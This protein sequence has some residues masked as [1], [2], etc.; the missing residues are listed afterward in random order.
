[1]SNARD[2]DH[3]RAIRA[4]HDGLARDIGVSNY[5]REQIEELIHASGETPVVNQI[6]WSSFGWSP[7]MLEYG[8]ERGIVI[9]AYSPL[10]RTERL[11]DG[12]LVEIAAE[13]GKTPA[14]LLLRWHLEL[15]SAPLP[16]ANRRDH[17]IENLGVFGFDISET[18]LVQLQR[19]NETYS[20]L[21]SLPYA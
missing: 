17:L 4:R 19:L 18:H 6:E 3:G 15:R 11:G 21:G 9:Q 14:Q 16:K 2:A 13:Y 8:R 1:M 5:S 12:R 20:S 7:E 10:R